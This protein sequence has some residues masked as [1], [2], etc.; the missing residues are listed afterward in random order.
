M[1]R[2][3]LALFLG[4]ALCLAAPFIWGPLALRWYRWRL[5]VTLPA[6]APVTVPYIQGIMRAP[7]MGPFQG[8]VPYPLWAMGMA[9]LVGGYVYARDARIAT[10]AAGGLLSVSL[11]CG[12]SSGLYFLGHGKWS[13][14]LLG[15]LY[16]RMG[17]QEERLFLMDDVLSWITHPQRQMLFA[18]GFWG[19][20]ILAFAVRKASGPPEQDPV[21][22]RLL[23]VGSLIAV[24][25]F[26]LLGIV[27][28]FWSGCF[29][30]DCTKGGAE[31]FGAAFTALLAYLAARMEMSGKTGQT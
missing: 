12:L 29:A 28:L 4:M 17:W 6:N 9:L 3:R 20:W 5:S 18:F 21:A 13:E 8:R 2:G 14:L 1:S 27:D 11:A 15:F 16:D 26:S 22:A 7:P 10:A 30:Y 24:V 25:V 23:R 31:P 19:V